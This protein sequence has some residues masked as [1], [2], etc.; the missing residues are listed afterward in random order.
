MTSIVIV[1]ISYGFIWN[2]FER[3]LSSTSSPTEIS[4]ISR[5]EFDWFIFERHE[6]RKIGYFSDFLTCKV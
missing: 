5:A 6:V 4:S 3:F 2:F 1:I